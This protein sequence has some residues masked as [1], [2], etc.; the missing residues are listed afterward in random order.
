MVDLVWGLWQCLDFE[1][2]QQVISGTTNMDGTGRLQT[3]EDVADLGV[4]NIEG[5]SHKLKE[6][7]ST[8]GGPFCYLYE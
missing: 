3:L 4:V 6:L 8:V 7:V 2:R 5:K 1:D